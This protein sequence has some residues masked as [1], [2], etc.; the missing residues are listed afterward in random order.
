VRAVSTGSSADDVLAGGAIF[1]LA[2]FAPFALL[3]FAPMIEGAAISHLE[4][5]SRRP[6]NAAR[7][8]ATRAA[9]APNTAL[10]ALLAGH[11]TSGSEDA[12]PAAR[13]VAGVGLAA[14]GGQVDREFALAGAA[15]QGGGSPP[16]GTPAGES[17]S[18]GRG[19]AGHGSTPGPTGPPPAGGGAS[20]ANGAEDGSPAGKSEEDFRV[21]GLSGAAWT[22]PGSEDD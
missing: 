9:N 16:G 21:T 6:V 17:G 5:V 14:T 10:G 20:A 18:G 8:A 13:A 11:G 22:G 15:A 7:S 2:A 19:P 3:R 12:A 4:G 1:L